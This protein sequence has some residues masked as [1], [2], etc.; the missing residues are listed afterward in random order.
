MVGPGFG[1]ELGV[2][3]DAVEEPAR[4]RD[5]IR[6]ARAVRGGFRG[7][8]STFTADRRRR[9]QIRTADLLPTKWFGPSVVAQA[10][11]RE[12]RALS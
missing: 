5:P 11:K 3:A 2:P 1:A 10:W 12:R 8:A 4:R 9:T 6:L 7:A